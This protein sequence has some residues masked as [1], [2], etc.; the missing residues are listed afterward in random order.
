M[1]HAEDAADWAESHPDAMGMLHR[2]YYFPQDII[3][4]F[5]PFVSSELIKLFSPLS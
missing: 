3:S 2:R 4:L 1:L 5:K